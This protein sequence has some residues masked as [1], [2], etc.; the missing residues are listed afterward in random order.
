MFLERGPLLLVAVAATGEPP[1]ALR[2]Q[3]AL[4]SGQLVSMLTNTIERLLQR[5]PRYDGHRLM[6]EPQE[7][8]GFRVYPIPAL[9]PAP[10]HG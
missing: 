8:P 3:L 10:T 9:R 5:N 7:L 4:V 2:R 1:A 6:G